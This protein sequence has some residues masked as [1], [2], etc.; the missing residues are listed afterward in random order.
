M[1]ITYL[2]HA[3]YS[4]VCGGCHFLI[5]PLLTVTCQDGTAEVWP[6]RRLSLS[7][8]PRVDVVVITHSH[9]GHLEVPSLALLPRDVTVLYPA[10]PTIELV[11]DGLGFSTRTVVGSGHEIE[12][13]GGQLTFTGSTAW[14][15]ELGCLFQEGDASCWYLVDTQVPNRDLERVRVRTSRIG[16]LIGNY[17]GYHHKFFTHMET[18]FPH[19]AS[20]IG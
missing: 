1:K 17:P 2:G 19:G 16:L 6:R 20:V 11:L 5:D 13:E 9:P 18:G 14:F 10:D 7:G 12:L 4:V 8:L 15:P 3:C